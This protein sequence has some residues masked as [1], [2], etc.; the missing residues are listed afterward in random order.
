MEFRSQGPA[1]NA[2]AGNYTINVPIQRLVY[3]GGDTSIVANLEYRI[4]IAG[5]VTLALF[6]DSG[7]NM[8]IRESQ[9]RLAGQQVN[10]LDNAQF[11]CPTYAINGSYHGELHGNA[12]R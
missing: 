11:G 12:C 7:M 5:P 4:P 8:A 10:E 2:L 1:N 6:V 3:P 9:L